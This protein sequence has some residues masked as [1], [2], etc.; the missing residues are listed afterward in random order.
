MLT[1]NQKNADQFYPEQAPLSPASTKLTWEVMRSID[2]DS[3]RNIELEVWEES[4]KGEFLYL[5]VLP[6]LATTLRI[7]KCV[8]N[9]N[10]VYCNTVYYRQAYYTN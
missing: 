10:T 6:N 9:G 8:L 2:P 1:K 5:I 7:K 4:R 3:Y